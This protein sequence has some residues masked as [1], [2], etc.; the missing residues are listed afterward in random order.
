MPAK[1]KL[2]RK[3]S[4]QSEARTS[5]ERMS[6]SFQYYAPPGDDWCLSSLDDAASFKR[7]LFS[8]KEI[9]NRTLKE[10]SANSKYWR[11]HPVDF[12]QTSMRQGFGIRALEHAEAYQFSLIGV[13]SQQCRVVGVYEGSVFYIVWV[14]VAH[15]LYPTEK[16]NT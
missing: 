8:L 1:K 6:F 16:K 7:A 11:F 3:G 14:D 4:A 15:Q 10:I 9:S 2:E 13:N 12:A 5:S